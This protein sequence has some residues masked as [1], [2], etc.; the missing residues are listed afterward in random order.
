[1]INAHELRIGNKFGYYHKAQLYCTCT[2]SSLGKIFE[3]TEFEN[4]FRGHILEGNL[5]P[6]ILTDEILENNCGFTDTNNGYRATGAEVVYSKKL[7]ENSK[8]DLWKDWPTGYR[9]PYYGTK[10][11]FLHQLQNIV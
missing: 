11:E 7:N 5:N 10:I 4:D 6:I 8:L 9:I 1:M 3:H 2:V